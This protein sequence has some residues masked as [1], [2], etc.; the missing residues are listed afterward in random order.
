MGVLTRTCS[1]P[2]FPLADFVAQAFL[3]TYLAVFRPCGRF[4]WKHLG[5]ILSWRCVSQCRSLG[6]MWLVGVSNKK[7]KKICVCARG[8]FRGSQNQVFLRFEP[9]KQ[10]PRHMCLDSKRN[11]CN[12]NKKKKRFVFGSKST[13]VKKTLFWSKNETNKSF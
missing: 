7:N 9:K 1:V 5:V 13:K 4:R 8:T 3:S 6:E 12:P 10:E 11:G 2:S